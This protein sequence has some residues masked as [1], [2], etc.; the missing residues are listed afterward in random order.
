MIGSLPQ[1]S[2]FTYNV[3]Q[4]PK[5]TIHHLDAFKHFR[6]HSKPYD[7][8][9]SAPTNPWIVGVE[10]LYTPYFYKLAKTSMNRGGILSQWMHT[11]RSDQAI[12]NTIFNNLLQ[13]FAYAEVYEV[14]QDNLIILASDQPLIPHTQAKRVNEPAIQNIFQKLNF[15]QKNTYRLLRKFNTVQLKYIAAAREKFYHSIQYPTLSIQSY[16]AFFLGENANIHQLIEPYIVRILNYYHNYD[17]LPILKQHIQYS[18]TAKSCSTLKQGI[19]TDLLCKRIIRHIESYRHYMSDSDIQTRLNAY[20]ALRQ[21]GLLPKDEV[22][23]EKVHEDLMAH[24]DLRTPQNYVGLVREYLRE[25]ITSKAMELVRTG[26]KMAL[27]S[28]DMSRQALSEIEA[29]ANQQLSAKQALEQLVV[30]H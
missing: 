11:S 12:L 6:R 30:Q 2:E 16:K 14:R 15:K 23:L 21:N 28:Q 20:A 4:N 5:L 27:L 8:V 10:N 18:D 13:V 9:I 17:L 3:H 29:I 25:G 7:I 22:F 19:E 1:F 24:A 26:T